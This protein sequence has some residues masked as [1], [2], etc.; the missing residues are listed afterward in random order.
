MFRRRMM[1]NK[2]KKTYLTIISTPGATLTINY[3]TTTIDTAG[4][5]IREIKGGDFIQYHIRKENYYG[6]YGNLSVPIGSDSIVLNLE[7]TPMPTPQTI[8]LFHCDGS[9]GTDEKGLAVPSENKLY[10]QFTG[11]FNW[12][13]EGYIE[14]KRNTWDSVF[15]SGAWTVDYW[16]YPK[17]NNGDWQ[18]D[19]LL[20]GASG[21]DALI[22][23]QTWTSSIQFFINMWG[24]WALTT[25]VPITMETWHHIA[26]TYDGSSITIYV[27]GK[28]QDSTTIAYL[29]TSGSLNIFGRGWNN[30]YPSASWRDEIRISKGVRWWNN[31]TPPTAAE[32]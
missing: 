7:L 24:N 6:K 18:V 19:M 23:Q 22:R 31:F 10:M 16:L 25:T 30:S 14:F 8:S 1:N 3:F 12:C 20:C 32:T 4:T 13:N 17:W 2:K 29:N 9:N 27:D 28:A 15:T 11:K 26:I 5:Y 21:G